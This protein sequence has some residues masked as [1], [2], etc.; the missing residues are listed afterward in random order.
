MTNTAFESDCLAPPWATP[1]E[2]T[3]RPLGG[4]A[5]AAPPGAAHH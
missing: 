2:M 4:R 5:T 3:V 1:H